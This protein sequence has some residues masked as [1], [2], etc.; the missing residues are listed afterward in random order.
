M[1]RIT[2]SLITLFL[3]S[4]GLSI[5]SLSC[6]KE[7]SAQVDTPGRNLGIITY[8]KSIYGVT[9]FWKCNYDGTGKTKINIPTLPDNYLLNG[10]FKV[11]PDGQK[12]FFNAYKV[13]QNGV[14]NRIYRMDIDGTN[15]LLIVGD[16]ASDD[17]INQAL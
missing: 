2:Y 15:L 4:A 5:V 9:E 3:L 1:K 6:N 10:Y 13:G 12:V 7:A 16:A 8:V 14:M 11:S 17:M